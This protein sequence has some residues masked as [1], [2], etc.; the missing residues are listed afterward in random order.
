MFQNL[1]NI[2]LQVH[3]EMKNILIFFSWQ[4][5]S[6]V[7]KQSGFDAPTRSLSRKPR[8]A[9]IVSLA[10]KKQ[11]ATDEVTGKISL[12]FRKNSEIIAST[13][14]SKV[15]A[16][17]WDRYIEDISFSICCQRRTL[18]QS[19]MIHLTFKEKY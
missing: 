3:L 5:L 19:N 18:T 1:I 8:Y 6:R 15:C 7:N 4:N 10:T 12:N 16:E 14:I 9:S 2:V 13:I 11:L 17:N